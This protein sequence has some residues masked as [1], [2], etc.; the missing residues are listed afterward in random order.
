MITSASS[1]VQSKAEQYLT[2]YIDTQAWLPRNMVFVNKAAFDK[3]APAEKKAVLD[4]AKTAEDRGWQLS[5]EEMSIKTKALKDAGIKVIAPT[6]EL[7]SGLAKIGETIA[8]EWAVAAGADG[9]AMLEAY[10]K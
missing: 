9:K 2:H 7:R 8:A 6:P 3:L 4:A 5:V 1:G 10:R